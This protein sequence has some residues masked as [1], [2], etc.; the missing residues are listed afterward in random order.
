MLVDAQSTQRWKK[1]FWVSLGVQIHRFN[2]L[3]LRTDTLFVLARTSQLKDYKTRK[4]LSRFVRHAKIP[5]KSREVML[6]YK[7]IIW[8]VCWR[9]ETLHISE[10]EQELLWKWKRLKQPCTKVTG[11]VSISKFGLQTI[12]LS[13]KP[14]W[15]TQKETRME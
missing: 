11:M 12:C 1:I 14:R 9:Q 15:V 7:N 5:W 8:N 2:V 4:K 10:W 6:M 13:Y 3:S